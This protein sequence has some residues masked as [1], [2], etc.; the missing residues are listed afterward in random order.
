MKQSK[1]RY[2]LTKSLAVVAMGLGLSSMS[3]SAQV[4]VD[5]ELLLLVDVSG[6]ISNSEYDLMMQGYVNAFTNGNI[7]DEIQSGDTGSIA[8]GLMFWSGNAEQ[9]LVVDWTQIS[10]L[11]SSQAFATSI[12]NV[13][14]SYS[15]STAVSSALNAGVATFGIETGNADNGFTSAAQII[16]ISGDG[17]END[18]ISVA[19]SPYSVGDARDAALV[20]GIDMINGLPIGNAGGSLD[21][22]YQNN[23]IG[24]SAGGV[25]AFT[26]AASSFSDFEN[27]LETKLASEISAGATESVPEP[28]SA[29]LLG[30]SGVL[31]IW[32]RK[33]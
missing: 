14:R 17:E 23:V 22:Y 16:D 15:G 8:V 1:Y 7:I 24:G 18:S 12:S 29:L 6:S 13:T 25:N 3:A 30:L 33:R 20:A 10:D 28:S 31:C 2:K 11:A 21:T 19:G 4:M 5:T 9:E 27:S 32:R 26:V